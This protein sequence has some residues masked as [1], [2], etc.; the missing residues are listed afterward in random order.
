MNRPVYHVVAGP[1]GAGKT[2]LTRSGAFDGVAIVDPDDLAR[3]LDPDAPEWVSFAAGKEAA[4]MIRNNI[5]DGRDFAQETTLSSVATLGTAREAKENG[6]AVE[7]HFV[8]VRSASQSHERVGDRVQQG[9]HNIPAADIDNRFPKTFANAERLAQSVDK[10]TFYDNSEPDRP[11]RV[12]LTREGRGMTLGD[13]PPAW[14]KTLHGRLRER[15]RVEVAREIADML[16]A[17]SDKE[18]AQAAVTLLDGRDVGRSP[19]PDGSSRE[20]GWSGSAPAEPGEAR[21]MPRP[22]SVD[23]ARGQVERIRAMQKERDADRGRD[24]E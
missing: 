11:C 6:F 8:G 2:T 1:N 18:R 12:V 19:A 10:S 22:G 20:A 3:R 16:P 24:R 23:H 7:M 21:A 14:A 9:G 4:R 13:D 15:D 5:E 17:G